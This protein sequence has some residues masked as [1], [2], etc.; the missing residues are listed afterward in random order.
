MKLNAW[1]KQKHLN[2]ID[3][4]NEIYHN[5]QQKLDHGVELHQMD[6]ID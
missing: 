1:M 5:Q 3:D 4:M 6:E 2:D